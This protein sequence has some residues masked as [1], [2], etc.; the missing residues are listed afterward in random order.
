MYNLFPGQGLRF[1]QSRLLIFGLY[2]VIILQL[3]SSDFGGGF[4]SS[5]K[6]TKPIDISVIDNAYSSKQ[7]DNDLIELLVLIMGVIDE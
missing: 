5:Y 2:P 1:S 6:T 3:T 4:V 7:D